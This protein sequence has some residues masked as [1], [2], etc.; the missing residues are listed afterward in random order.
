MKEF[1][2]K[3]EVSEQQIFRSLKLI[4]LEIFR[5]NRQNGPSIMLQTLQIKS[6]IVTK[7]FTEKVTERQLFG[8]KHKVQCHITFQ[9]A[10]FTQ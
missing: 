7:H 8:F 2:K 9:R 3:I 1:L 6:Q 10:T 5:R 4:V